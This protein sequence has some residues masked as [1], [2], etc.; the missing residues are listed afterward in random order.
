MSVITSHANLQLNETGGDLQKIEHL[1]PTH[2]LFKEGDEGINKDLDIHNDYFR[3]A[4]N[5]FISSRL[6]IL[7]PEQKWEN[8]ELRDFIDH[9]DA[10]NIF[11]S[12]INPYKVDPYSHFAITDNENQ[13]DVKVGEPDMVNPNNFVNISTILRKIGER[14]GVENYCEGSERKWLLNHI[15]ALNCI[16]Q[17]LLT[18]SIGSY[19]FLVCCI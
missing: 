7:M 5:R 3:S 18:N 11:N 8:G 15:I 1:K 17:N 19:K 6:R 4:R 2:W 13:V 14:T 12:E 9:L 10:D 16:T